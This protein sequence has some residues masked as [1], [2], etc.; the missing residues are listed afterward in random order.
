MAKG[1]KEKI[2]QKVI[3]KR[4]GKMLQ[5]KNI[6]GILYRQVLYLACYIRVNNFTQATNPFNDSKVRYIFY[7][8]SEQ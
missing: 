8:K 4:Y 7:V 2:W 6:H 1:N 5:T 3:D